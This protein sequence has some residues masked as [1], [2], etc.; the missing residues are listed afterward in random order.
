MS[1]LQAIEFIDNPALAGR[2]SQYVTI[3]VNTEK[4]LKSW[5]NSLFS[6]EWLN[7]D[8]TIKPLKDLPES[9]QPKRQ[10]VEERLSRCQPIAKPVLGI[11]LQDNI[12]IGIGRAEFL[13]LAACGI[14]TITVQIP[15]SNEQDFAPFLA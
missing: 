4:A 11:G 9:E 1:E 14:G 13:T 3:Q 7:S 2:E 12:E 10:D 6:F 8:G 15:K 5:Q